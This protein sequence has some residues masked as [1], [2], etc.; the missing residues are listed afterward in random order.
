[1]TTIAPKYAYS[2]KLHFFLGEIL[3]DMG[4]RYRIDRSWFLEQSKASTNI[5]WAHEVN[6]FPNKPDDATLQAYRDM[7]ITN[8]KK[9]KKSE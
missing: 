1:M 6:V 7:C 9:Y 3:D 8:I 4:D 2:K 5:V